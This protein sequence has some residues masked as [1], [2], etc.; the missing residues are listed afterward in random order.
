[1]LRHCL[2]HNVHRIGVI[3]EACVRT[4]LLDVAYDLLH[5]SDG[6]QSHEESRRTLSL[7]PND[8]ILQRN[9][10]VEMPGLETA[11]PKTGENS[12]AIL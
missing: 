3:E 5:H 8:A 2:R 1:M 6:S 11:R 9:A 12:I 4:N 10:L 7:L